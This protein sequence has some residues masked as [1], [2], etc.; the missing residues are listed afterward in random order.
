MK[1]SPEVEARRKDYQQLAEALIQM[2]MLHGNRSPEVL[3][4]DPPG[5]LDSEPEPFIL[6]T[7]IQEHV[8]ALF[9]NIT[10]TYTDEFL[11][12]LYVELRLFYDEKMLE[13]S[14]GAFRFVKRNGR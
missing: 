13:A 7:A 4:V 1:Y 8:R 3:D 6:W 9:E 14:A 12:T 5:W 11:R 2:L 10:M